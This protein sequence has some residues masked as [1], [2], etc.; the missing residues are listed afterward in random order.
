MI[1]KHQ[2]KYCRA[3]KKPLSNGKC[4]ECGFETYAHASK[5][6]K[7]IQPKLKECYYCCS[8]EKLKRDKLPGTT[9]WIYLC[10]NCSDRVWAKDLITRFPFLKTIDDPT[11]RHVR[12]VLGIQTTEEG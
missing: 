7:V 11:G 1:N 2:I 10:P 6:K 8:T 5:S 4:L 9:P 12:N 3:C